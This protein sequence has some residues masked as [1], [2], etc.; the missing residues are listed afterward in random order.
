MWYIFHQM[1]IKSAIRRPMVQTTG[2]TWRLRRVVTHV[3]NGQWCH[4]NREFQLRLIPTRDSEH[5]ITAE[6]QMVTLQLGVT[7]HIIDD[8]GSVI[9]ASRNLPA[10][11]CAKCKQ[12]YSLLIAFIHYKTTLKTKG[13]FLLLTFLWHKK[14]QIANSLCY[15]RQEC[16]IDQFRFRIHL[17]RDCKIWRCP[18]NF[19]CMVGHMTTS[20]IHHN[21]VY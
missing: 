12:L 14:N 17:V 16:S 20:G 1:V 9:S 5:T 13:C 6:T 10:L 8:G 15:T 4:Q 7:R 18:I 3:N 2:A 19:S 11:V 21:E